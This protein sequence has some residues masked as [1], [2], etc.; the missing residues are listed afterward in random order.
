MPYRIFVINP[1]STSTKVA[2]FED[3]H[4]L[5]SASILHSPKE[6]SQFASVPDQLD[7]R[8]R[9][10][11]YALCEAGETLEGVDAYATRVSGLTSCK[12]GVYLIND[13]LLEHARIGFTIMHPAS[14]GCQIA[15]RFAAKRGCPALVVDPPEVDELDPAA[16][17]TGLHGVYRA[18]H[19]HVLNQKE[20]ARRYARSVGKRYDEINVVVAH[21]GGGIS[22]GA[23][24]LGKIVDANDGVQGDGPMAPTRAGSLPASEL[25]RLCYSG[26]Y[27][28]DEMIDLVTAR[29]GWLDHLLTSDLR[30]AK[31][32]SE[33]GDRY[34]EMVLEATVLGIVKSIGAYAAVLGGPEA[35]LLTGGLVKSEWLA[36]ELK[37]RVGFIAP[38]KIYPGEF[39][40]EAMAHGA[41]RVLS[42]A[43]EPL[44]YTGEGVWT[45][46]ERTVRD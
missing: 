21:L 10:I 9:A 22:V 15:A 1:G 13:V 27:T 4:M 7:F 16:H 24:R 8:V 38:V 18:C 17:L 14:L 28:K 45:P 41:Y 42:G 46:P 29:G 2:L 19:L 30:A 26:R 3:E 44:I 23:H 32:M 35:I 40:M 39:E 6:L 36:G 5:F 25:I 33:D 34:A 31:K 12:S 11:E 20:V 43:E 37:R